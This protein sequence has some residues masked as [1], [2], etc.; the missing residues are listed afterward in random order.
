M[1]PVDGNPDTWIEL[2]PASN[3]WLKVDLGREGLVTGVRLTLS[4]I[5]FGSDKAIFN[6]TV[7]NHTGDRRVCTTVEE[8][9]VMALLA[10]H[11]VKSCDEPLLGRFVQV[12]TMVASI[13]S[14]PTCD[15][16]TLLHEVEV[17]LGKENI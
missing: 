15:F 17:M 8:Y 13:C 6:V 7:T 10:N 1:L 2:G 11:V 9:V 5:N 14:T 16:V 12:E 3:P 4:V